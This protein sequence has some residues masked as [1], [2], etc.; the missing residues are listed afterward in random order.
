[1]KNN[2]Y[3]QHVRLF[4][5]YD[6]DIKTFVCLKIIR[7]IMNN[8]IKKFPT[9]YD[10]IKWRRDSF[11][12]YHSSS[13]ITQNLDIVFSLDLVTIDDRFLKHDSTW[14][15]EYL[16]L[17]FDKNSFC[18]P[19]EVLN[20]A[21]LERINYAQETMYNSS[22]VAEKLLS[23]QILN[24]EDSEILYP[25]EMETI[26][27]ISQS[28]ILD[29]LHS[30]SKHLFKVSYF[31]I[32]EDKLNRIKTLIP[33]FNERT[34]KFNFQNIVN[35]NICIEE[36]KKE[37][38]SSL[39][40]IAFKFNCKSC[41]LTSKL[42]Y[43]YLKSTKSFIFEIIREKY[44]LIYSYY[45]VTHKNKNYFFLEMNIEKK[46]I[47]LVKNI[48][49]DF[50][51]DPKKYISNSKFLEIKKEYVNFMKSNLKSQEYLYDFIDYQYFDQ[52]V[53]TLEEFI[54]QIKNLT[55]QDFLKMIKS[56]SL[57]SEC[58]VKGENNA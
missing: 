12:G 55:Y 43:Y 20:N 23:K 46:S 41:F 17:I 42:V 24:K 30:L 4:F 39:Y 45:V 7:S 6:F 33:K 58:F 52:K 26:K 32:K 38:S 19:Q 51:L 10:Y 21:K 11:G 53:Y 40:L 44:G 37:L 54:K 16:T 5:H 25:E 2:F 34:I 29:I 49:N 48:I 9:K 47:L 56:I 57:S 3:K 15:E 36:S 13:I 50:L 28:D 1:M 27:Q 35:E 14:I 22:Y 31:N 18:V 8:I